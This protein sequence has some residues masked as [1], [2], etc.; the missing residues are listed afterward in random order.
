LPT[1]SRKLAA[2]F[3]APGMSDPSLV[4]VAQ[5]AAPLAERDLMMRGL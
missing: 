1:A 3:T 4:D 2:S 5:V